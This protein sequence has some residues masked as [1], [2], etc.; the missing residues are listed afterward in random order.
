MNEGDAAM[1]NCACTVPI[2]SKK[3]RSMAR[4]NSPVLMMGA[5]T[6]AK[7]VASVIYFP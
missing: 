3:N 6:E 7:T 5:D 2:S 1:P 4:T